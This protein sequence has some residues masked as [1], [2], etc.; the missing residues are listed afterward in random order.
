[1]FDADKAGA[2]GTSPSSPAIFAAFY[3]LLIVYCAMVPFHFVPI[4]PSIAWQRLLAI[5]Y[6][7]HGSDQRADWMGNLVMLVPL[8][9]AV[10]AALA[11]K[12]G[13]RAAIGGLAAFFLCSIVVLAVK[14]LQ[15]FFPGRT[16]TINYVIAQLAGAAIGIL[17]Q[18]SSRPVL[19]WIGAS[20]AAG[21]RRAFVTLLWLYAGSLLLFIL[22]PF[23]FVLSRGDFVERVKAL[24]GFFFALPGQHLGP[25]RRLMLIA[26]LVG[27]TVPLGMLWALYYPRRRIALVLFAAICAT[28]M[29][30]AALLVMSTRPTAVGTALRAVG[31]VAGAMVSA[32]AARGLIVRHV[33]ILRR[34]AP[35]LAIAYLLLLVPANGIKPANLHLANLALGSIDPRVWLPFFLWYNIGKGA[36]AFAAMA[37]ALLY[38]PVGLLLWRRPLLA[39]LAAVFVSAIMEV[40]RVLTGLQPDPN[41]LLVAA[42]AA[43][44]TAHYAPI[45]WNWL[46]DHPA[47][48]ENA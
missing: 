6:I 28:A 37:H 33:F 48:A 7:E 45:V 25:V 21:G 4:D 26:A 13:G 22:L 2:A 38:L 32:P 3:I 39:A 41:N 1:M 46:V 27:E 42:A 29:T 31:I 35:I 30:L 34:A 19:A 17:L 18:I 20:T 16:V 12:P 8:G 23:D 44:V 36:A 11:P 5:A 14:Y 10:T 9:Y 24:P 15:L 47:P 43:S 40:G